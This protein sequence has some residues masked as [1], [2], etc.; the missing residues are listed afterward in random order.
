V[1]SGEKENED[2]DASY[3]GE[4]NQREGDTWGRL[5]MPKRL[6][7]VASAPGSRPKPPAASSCVALT[8][9]ANF[10]LFTKMPLAKFYKLLSNFL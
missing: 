1:S 5:A 8:I 9:E 3:I 2:G 6:L 7:A 4:A 10:K